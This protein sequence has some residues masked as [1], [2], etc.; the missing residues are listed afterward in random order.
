MPERPSD[1][2]DV[3]RREVGLSKGELWLRFVELGGNHPVAYAGMR[4]TRR[5]AGDRPRLE[6]PGHPCQP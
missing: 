2:L 4:T 5:E 1:V 3:A 6:K